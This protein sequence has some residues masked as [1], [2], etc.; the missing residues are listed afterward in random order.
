MRIKKHRW[1][2]NIL[3]SNDP[4]IFSIG[5]RRFQSLPVFGVEDPGDRLRMIKYTPQHDFCFA[6][7]YGSFA[8][9]DT[10]VLCTQTVSS[11]IAKFRIAATGYVM[12]LNH[13]FQIQKKLKLIGEPFKI[14]KNTAYVKGMFNSALEVA[15]FEGA[16]IKTVSGIRGQIK[17]AI[18][19]GVD[20]SFR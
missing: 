3:K 12:E 8:P 14:F 7:F 17:K 18:K 1:Y 10:G 20:G 5:W 15:K 19:E 4:L 11:D 9:Q 16:P 13:S 6:V 2:T